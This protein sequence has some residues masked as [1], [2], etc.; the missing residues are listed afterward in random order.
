MQ[1]LL[2]FAE[3]RVANLICS[4]IWR[5]SGVLVPISWLSY[6]AFLSSGAL[7]VGA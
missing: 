2:I 4:K 5:N 3:S 6:I 1:H 7:D